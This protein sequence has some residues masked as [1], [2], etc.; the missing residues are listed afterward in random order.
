MSQV[1]DTIKSLR[2]IH[3]NFSGQEI[4]AGH[5]QT[6]LKASVRAANASGRQ[7]YSIVVLEERE[8]I[9]E[10]CQYV[11]SKALVFCVDFTRLAD[12]ADHL[13]YEYGPLLNQ[14]N[15]EWFIPA[16]TDTALAAQTAAIAAKSLGIDSLFTNSILRGDISRVYRLLDLPEANCF[17]LIALVL[18][19]PDKEP[20]HKKGRLCGPGVI[21]QGKYSR[22]TLEETDAMIAEF[23]DPASHLALGWNNK[24]HEHYLD[25][26]FEAWSNCPRKGDTPPDRNEGRGRSEQLVELMTRAGFL[27]A[28]EKKFVRKQ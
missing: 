1:L 16:A 26:F 8:V 19:Y 24:E 25:W 9:K 14:G 5:L 7:S 17:P 23:D 27:L 22:L 6:I 11:G 13:G 20:A 12:L 28:T 2:T 18:G 3:G 15:I 10:V 4:S 21:H